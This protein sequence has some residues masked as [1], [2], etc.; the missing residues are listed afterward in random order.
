MKLSREEVNQDAVPLYRSSQC[1]KTL[2][3]GVKVF[4][5]FDFHGNQLGHYVVFVILRRDGV[6]REVIVYVV[7][8]VTDDF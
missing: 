5:K 4:G 1:D 6:I 7:S 8:P 3:I 2:V